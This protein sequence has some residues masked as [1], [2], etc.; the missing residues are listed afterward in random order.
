METDRTNEGRTEEV[1]KAPESLFFLSVF[2]SVKH[3]K[4]MEEQG[5]QNTLIK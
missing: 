5:F 2:K 4:I 3:I 1:I